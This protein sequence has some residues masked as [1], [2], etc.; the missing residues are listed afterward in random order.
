MGKPE[1]EF[2]REFKL[3]TKKFAIDVLKLSDELPYNQNN[4]KI[5][6]NNKEK[7]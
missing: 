5:T 3:R 2:V 4:L 6:T 7:P 1:N